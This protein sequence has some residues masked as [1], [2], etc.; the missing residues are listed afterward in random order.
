VPIIDAHHHLLNPERITYPFLEFLPEL[1]RFIGP[2]E[3]GGLLAAAGVDAT[4][5]VQAADSEDE[6][7]FM[8]EQR[9]VAPF[10]AG[11]IGWVPLRDPRSTRAALERH[12]AGGSRLVGIR[13]LIHDETD[14]DWIIQPNVLD[15]L[16]LLAEADLTF[17]L[18]AFQ[19]RHLEHVETIVAAAPELD[20]VICHFG[21]PS[22]DVDAWEPWATPF[23]QAATHPRCAV[24]VSGLDMY[25][26]GCDAHGFRPYFAH[27]LEHFGTERMIWASNWPVSLR[28]A[29]YGELLETAREVLSDC[30]ANA[31]QEI[32]GGNANRIYGLGL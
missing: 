19:P 5:C 10:I 17:D 13:H 1:D 2:E 23:A 9:A 11:V 12:R 14:P 29:G 7:A 3:L 26:G 20:V 25:R 4:I 16:Q 18:S 22:T 28:G 8:L 15:S 32:F 30:D 24:K 21:M 6:T 31:H 27:A